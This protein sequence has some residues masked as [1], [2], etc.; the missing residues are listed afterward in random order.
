[1]TEKKYFLFIKMVVPAEVEAL[2]LP[3]VEEQRVRNKESPTE[4]MSP[5]IVNKRNNLGYD[6]SDEP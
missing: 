5:N 1:M 4:D 6:C 2:Q 3:H